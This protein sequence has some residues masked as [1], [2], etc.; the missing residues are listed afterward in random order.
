MNAQIT[1][2]FFYKMM[3]FFFPGRNIDNED[4]Q[5]LDTADEQQ[6]QQVFFCL[7][8]FFNLNFKGLFIGKTIS[9]CSK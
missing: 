3:A 9:R 5:N 1:H 6:S 7:K 4:Q 8:F 2:R